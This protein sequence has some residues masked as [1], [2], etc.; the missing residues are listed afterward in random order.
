MPFISL[1]YHL[2]NL[3]YLG[4]QLCW[5]LGQACWDDP[6]L[7]IP[8]K[9]ELL[10][11][12]PFLGSTAAVYKKKKKKG[13]CKKTHLLQPADRKS[14]GPDPGINDWGRSQSRI[15]NSS[16]IGKEWDSETWKRDIQVDVL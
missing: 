12:M 4:E 5:S 14:W 2:R 8:E 13:E 10:L 1:L 3:P 6:Y 7:L 11:T 15:L 9:S 16:L